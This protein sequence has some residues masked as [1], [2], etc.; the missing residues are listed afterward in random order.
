MEWVKW[1]VVGIL[2]AMLI[3]VEVLFIKVKRWNNRK[4]GDGE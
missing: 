4:D 1:L 3:S 2:I